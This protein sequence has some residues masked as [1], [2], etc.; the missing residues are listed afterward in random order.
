MCIISKKNDD[1]NTKI[2]DH[3]EPTQIFNKKFC[4]PMP[5]QNSLQDVVIHS[6]VSTIPN[7]MRKKTKPPNEDTIVP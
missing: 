3:E 2:W 6:T 1:K 7:I 4:L 5:V